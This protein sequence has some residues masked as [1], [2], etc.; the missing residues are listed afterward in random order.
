MTVSEH[1][2]KASGKMERAEDGVCVWWWWG[3]CEMAA[4]VWLPKANLHVDPAWVWRRCS[5]APPL[6][7]ELLAV[8]GY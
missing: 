1:T 7:E 8:D 4:A 5:H 2:T 3:S 6:A